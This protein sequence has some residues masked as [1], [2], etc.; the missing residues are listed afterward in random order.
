[1]P[2]LLR[3]ISYKKWIRT[4]DL[5]SWLNENEIPADSLNNLIFNLKNNSLSAWK[6]EDDN[7]N[8]NDIIIALAT[9]PDYI[10][11]LSYILIDLNI[12]SK[13]GIEYNEING[14]T[15]YDKANQLW[16]LNLCKITGKKAL[17]LAQEFFN[18]GE[19]KRIYKKQLLE[20]FEKNLE[21]LKNLEIK[22]LKDDVRKYIS[23][24][25]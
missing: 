19:K 23:K 20:L 25:I 9:N 18:K 14:E 6:V 11:E 21:I 3:K 5:D 1:M 12:L 22:N 17:I 7:S 13:Y 8:L 24:L 16:H 15:K 2:F 4:S 10:S